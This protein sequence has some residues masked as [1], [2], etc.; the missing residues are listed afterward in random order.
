MR[1]K[2]GK[3][4]CSD[5]IMH[6]HSET[7]KTIEFIKKNMLLY[8]YYSL[9][10]QAAIFVFHNT[11]GV[12]C[13]FRSNGAWLLVAASYL[14]ALACTGFTVKY[15]YDY[16]LLQYRLECFIEPEFSLTSRKVMNVPYFLNFNPR[17]TN[18]NF[19][20]AFESFANPKTDH[21]QWMYFIANWSVC[22]LVSYSIMPTYMLTLKQTMTAIFLSLIILIV[23]LFYTCHFLS[24]EKNERFKKHLE[25]VKVLDDFRYAGLSEKRLRERIKK[26]LSK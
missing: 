14:I 23:I 7:T 20:D 21:F 22:L 10:L 3:Y 26:A 6:L 2:H 25:Y 19:F 1:S 4:P 13:F 9:T 17:P 16:K 18:K 5:E 24:E 12:N 8:L 11:D 15:F